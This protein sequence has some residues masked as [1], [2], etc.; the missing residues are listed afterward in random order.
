MPLL[1]IANAQPYFHYTSCSLRAQKPLHG[2]IASISFT[3]G[4]E[5]R[6]PCAWKSLEK[7]K[8]VRFNEGRREWSRGRLLIKAV[9][10]LEPKRLAADEDKCLSFKDSDAGVNSN[11]PVVRHDSCNEEPEELD[12]KE[13]MR[14]M[15][16]SKAN[17]GNTPWNKGRKH[18]P[19]TLQKIRERTRLAMQNPKVRMKLVDLGH[20]QTMAT[21]Q[22]IG[23]GVRKGWE[24]RMAKRMVQEA[25]IFEWQNLIAEASRQG[26]VGEEEMQWKSYETLNEQLQQEWLESIEQRKIMQR[27]PHSKR[28]PKSLE[29]RRK[30]AEAISA[31]WADPEYRQRVCSA[32][33]KYHGTSDKTERKP[34]RKPSDG[35][36][37]PRR[38]SVKKSSS[39][40]RSFAKSNE[41]VLTQKLRRR[42][43]PVYKDPL[44]SFKF[45][46]IMNI[47]AQR[48]AAETKQTEAV[49]RARLLIAEAEKAANAL[50]VAAT[51][52]PIAQA[53]LIETRKLINEA[54]Q[55]LESIETQLATESTVSSSG[56]LSEIDRGEGATLETS[57]QSD[58]GPVNGHKA[59]P[60]SDYKLPDGKFP[61]HELINGDLKLHLSTTNDIASS[62]LSFESESDSTNQPKETLQDPGME[63]KADPS[64]PGMEIQSVKDETPSKSL[65]VTKKWVRGRLVEVVEETH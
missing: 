32:L 40:T 60:S 21:R 61:L 36:E 47:R 1:E 29:Q 41:R 9:A 45:D 49:E 6:L 58:T 5:L 31:K 16:I 24:R 43:S 63:H 14:R 11:R 52:S 33:A 51:K 4:K 12:E 20:A 7:F 8:K 18:S 3:Y 30:I 59:L 35:T 65:T 44:A 17:S 48:A 42:K 26:F 25:C 62:A 50:E 27:A 13:K 39:E 23:I 57:N 38:N 53:S 22:K 10:T 15:R 54:I 2:K 19:E 64:P 28:A 55:S 56:S 34:R 37:S 46:M